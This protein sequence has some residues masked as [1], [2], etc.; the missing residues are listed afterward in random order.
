[1]KNIVGILLFA[2]IALYTHVCVVAAATIT[3]VY[4][5]LNRLKEV[6]YQEAGYHTLYLYD[7]VGNVHQATTSYID[8]DQD[9]LADVLENSGCTDPLVADSDNDGLVDGEEDSNHDGILDAGETDL[10]NPDTDNDTMLDGWEVLYGF[11][12]LDP[13]DADLDSDGD[14]LSNLDEFGIGTTPTLTDT[15]SDGVEDGFDGYPL[16]GTASDCPVTVLC[17]ETSEPYSSLQQAFDDPLLID[18]DTIQCTAGEFVGD[19]QLNQDKT[20]AFQGGFFCIYTD[21]P[22]SSTIVGSLT[23]SN[24]RLLGHPIKKRL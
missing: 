11:D 20:L 24:G 18:G 8:T 21:N 7:D 10:C 5:D 22:S 12:P 19:F 16:D 15:D 9:G 2:L 13:T 6:I 4:D 1:M 14:G 23:I 17:Y 3:Y